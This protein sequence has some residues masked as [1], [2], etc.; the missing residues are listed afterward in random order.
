MSKKCTLRYKLSYIFSSPPLPYTHV[1]N[2]I[3][4]ICIWVSVAACWGSFY[5]F[6][7]FQVTENLSVT[8][9]QDCHNK[10]A[11]RC[12][13][14]MPRVAYCGYKWNQHLYLHWKQSRQMC[15]VGV[16]QGRSFSSVSAFQYQWGC[17]V[18]GCLRWKYNKERHQQKQF[19]IKR[20][21]RVAIMIYAQ[22][23][24]TSPRI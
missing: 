24:G 22:T 2:P 4:S 6:Y 10:V 12:V 5:A 7:Q 20:G 16:T 8:V 3:Q 14:C 19:V 1:K 13:A 11:N 9:Q 17:C 15:A 23:G 21:N 18:G